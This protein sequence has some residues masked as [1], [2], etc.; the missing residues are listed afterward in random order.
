MN[1]VNMCQGSNYQGNFREVSDTVTR[2]Q[3]TKMNDAMKYNPM[4]AANEITIFLNMELLKSVLAV[5]PPFFVTAWIPLAARNNAANCQK[6][7]NDK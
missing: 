1:E 3:H 5:I 4:V 2:R 7:K 6:S